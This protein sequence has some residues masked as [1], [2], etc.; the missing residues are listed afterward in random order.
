[1]SIKKYIITLVAK[2]EPGL[3]QRLSEIVQA[4]EGNWLESSLS[5]LGGHFTGIVRVEISGDQAANFESA[6]TALSNDTL[7]AKVYLASDEKAVSEYSNKAHIII[8]A[9]DRPGIVEEISSQLL[10]LGI[11]V[12]NMET[13]CESAP[14]SGYSLFVASLEIALPKNV[15]LQQMEEALEGLSDDLMLTISS[16]DN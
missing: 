16:D 15:S 2:D 4:H 9:N 7:T 8:E 12:E 13:H 6:I 10:Q 1:M 5:R 3:V 11:N 14:M